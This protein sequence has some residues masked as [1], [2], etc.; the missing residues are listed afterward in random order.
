MVSRK[1][2]DSLSVQA[3]V[4]RNFRGSAIGLLVDLLET[5]SFKKKELDEVE[6]YLREYCKKHE[7]RDHG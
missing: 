6:E 5:G 7:I 1:T 3:L 2:I 4:S